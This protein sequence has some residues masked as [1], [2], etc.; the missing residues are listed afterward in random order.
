M[1]VV[2]MYPRATVKGSPI[3]VHN[4]LGENP[5]MSCQK[6]P[7]LY[8]L[9]SPFGSNDPPIPVAQSISIACV[10]S[11]FS[12]NKRYQPLIFY[13]LKTYFNSGRKLVKQSDI[14]AVPIDTDDSSWISK[15]DKE[16]NE[17][18]TD[19]RYDTIAYDFKV[20]FLLNTRHVTV[21][22]HQRYNEVLFFKVTNTNCGSNSQPS[23]SSQDFYGDSAL[24]NLG[25][26]VDPTI[27]RIVQ[28]GVVHSRVPK[29]ISYMPLG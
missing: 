28:T 18:F 23:S 25:C 7:F 4:I 21:A 1:T 3:L 17:K 26:W 6:Q 9:P 14:L 27:T 10:A 8:L 16:S 19:P 5:R 15:T 22:R 2:F 12:M 29:V 20:K 11:C 24:G 13:A